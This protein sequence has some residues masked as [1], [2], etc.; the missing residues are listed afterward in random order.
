MGSST[1]RYI[2]TAWL[3]FIDTY[4]SHSLGLEHDSASA[5]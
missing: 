2:K 1:R 5:G 3:R 4:F